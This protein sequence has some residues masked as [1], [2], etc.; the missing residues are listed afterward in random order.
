MSASES[1]RFTIHLIN[2][3]VIVGLDEI[4]FMGIINYKKSYCND[5]PDNLLVILNHRFHCAYMI[6]HRVSLELRL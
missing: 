4:I 1:Y 3:S 2:L 6:F 5:P